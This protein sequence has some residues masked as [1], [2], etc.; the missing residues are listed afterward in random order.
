M[1]SLI[2][3]RYMYDAL[4]ARLSIRGS[5]DEPRRRLALRIIRDIELYC[6]DH[7][8][9]VFAGH[10]RLLSRTDVEGVEMLAYLDMILASFA[11]ADCMA[12]AALDK[13]KSALNADC[14]ADTV[15][16]AICICPPQSRWPSKKAF[17]PAAR[18]L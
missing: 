13:G 18:E 1:S 14:M 6:A 12:H 7:M 10:A 15:A 17:G 8:D 4:N 2:V 16:S 9:D 5:V 3:E 11:D